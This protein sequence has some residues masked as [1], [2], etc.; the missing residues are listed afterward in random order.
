MNKKLYIAT[1]PNGTITI[2]N[3]KNKTK[4][5]LLLD[6]EGNPEE[7]VVKE[8]SFDDNIHIATNLTSN[9]IEWSLGEY[10]ND[11]V[12]EDYNIY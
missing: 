6:S 2:F 7:A 11:A 12:T 9:G 5:L 1:W 4:R 10:A 8:I 3:A